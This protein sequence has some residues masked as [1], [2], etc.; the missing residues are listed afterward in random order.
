MQWNQKAL[1]NVDL[2]KRK[3]EGFKLCIKVYC[4]NEG[5]DQLVSRYK[6]KIDHIMLNPGVWANEIL[7]LKDIYR[8]NNNGGLIYIQY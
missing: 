8:T 5:K 4:R 6:Y 1:L 7:V 2:L 3:F